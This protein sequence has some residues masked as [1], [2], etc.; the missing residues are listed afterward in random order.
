MGG[1]KQYPLVYCSMDLIRK[2]RTVRNM[3]RLIS[4]LLLWSLVCAAADQPDNR[5]YL[6]KAIAPETLSNWLLAAV[7]ICAA[8]MAWRT[9]LTLMNQTIATKLPLMPPC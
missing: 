3:K 9:L 6:Q 2:S 5:S 4:L 8:I 7:G 1:V